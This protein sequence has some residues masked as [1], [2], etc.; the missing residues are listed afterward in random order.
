[1]P[2]LL[3]DSQDVQKTLSKLVAQAWLDEEFK[4]RLISDTVTVLEENGLTLPSGVQ[5]RVNENTALW[6]LTSAGVT[7]NSNGVYE[8][9]LPAKPTRLTDQQLQSWAKQDNL[10]TFIAPG[11]LC[12]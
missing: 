7:T 11:S 6:D 4:K 9:P 10:N 2:T 8:I 12:S 3:V 1:M 5:V